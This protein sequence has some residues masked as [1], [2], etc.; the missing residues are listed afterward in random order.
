MWANGAWSLCSGSRAKSQED[1]PNF[2]PNPQRGAH[3]FGFRPISEEMMK[4]TRKTTKSSFANQAAVPARLLKPKT[5]AM[6]A[7]SRKT[8]A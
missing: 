8:A 2:R 6:I 5:Q 4:A 7:M 1:G 3:S